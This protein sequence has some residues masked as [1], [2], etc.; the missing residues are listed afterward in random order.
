MYFILYSTIHS[1]LLLH[2]IYTLLIL[3]PVN[4]C[5]CPVN[6]HDARTLY[7]NKFSTLSGALQYIAATCKLCINGHGQWGRF[8]STD[9]T[10]YCETALST[11]SLP[12]P[13]MGGVLMILHSNTV[14]RNNVAWDKFLYK[15][16]PTTTIRL[17][18]IYCTY[19]KHS[20]NSTCI[21]QTANSC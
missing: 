19:L 5:V 13:P 11:F 9:D 8:L 3:F 15:H 2:C 20:T 18:M 21:Q 17:H 6:F 1:P 12:R 7:L 16:F 14:Q 4:S 10:G